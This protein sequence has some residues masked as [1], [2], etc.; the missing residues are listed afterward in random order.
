LKKF[1]F[2]SLKARLIASII[3]ENT[4]NLSLTLCQEWQNPEFFRSLGNMLG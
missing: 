3:V 1:L 4:K 2:P